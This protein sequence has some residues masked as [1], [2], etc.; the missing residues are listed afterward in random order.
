LTKNQIDDKEQIKKVTVT[1]DDVNAD[2][3]EENFIK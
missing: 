1:P 3:Q 2:S